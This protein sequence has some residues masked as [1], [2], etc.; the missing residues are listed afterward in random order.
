[1]SNAGEESKMEVETDADRLTS[2][3]TGAPETPQT[4]AQGS[5]DPS[6]PPTAALLAEQAANVLLDAE[7]MRVFRELQVNLDSFTAMGRLAQLDPAAFKALRQVYPGM[8]TSLADMLEFGT[9]VRE[10]QHEDRAA[11]RRDERARRT[12]RC[13]RTGAR[14]CTIGAR[15]CWCRRRWRAADTVPPLIGSRFGQ[16]DDGDFIGDFGDLGLHSRPGAQARQRTRQ[17]PDDP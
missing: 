5:S 4:Q 17:P 7:H 1:M 13:G 3:S 11:R 6:V 12:P 14:W 2:A 15:W 16:L 8:L 9:K 10:Q